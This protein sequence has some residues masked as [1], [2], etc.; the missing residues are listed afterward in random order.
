MHFKTF[1]ETTFM[2]GVINVFIKNDHVV[3]DHSKMVSYHRISFLKHFINV[4]S[5]LTNFRMEKK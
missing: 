2:P 1:N 4:L 5:F 3:Y